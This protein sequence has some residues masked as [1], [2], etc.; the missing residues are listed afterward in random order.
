[1]TARAYR[2]LEVVSDGRPLNGVIRAAYEVH[3][4]GCEYAVLGLGDTVANAERELR[5]AGW[6]TKNRLWMCSDCL[7]VKS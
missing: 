1:M 4:A 7:K 2:G 3:C 5:S 6:A